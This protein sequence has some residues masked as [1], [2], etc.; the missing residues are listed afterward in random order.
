[1]KNRKNTNRRMVTDGI[2]GLLEVGFLIAAWVWVFL[3]PDDIF[4]RGNADLAT[5]IV[6][7]TLW[8]MTLT[9]KIRQLR[10]NNEE[11]KEIC[12]RIQSSLLAENTE[13]RK[14]HLADQQQILML[15][16]ERKSLYLRNCQLENDWRQLENLVKQ[17]EQSA[18]VYEAE[19]ELPK[20]MI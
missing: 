10:N 11:L 9:S 6:L 7:I 5:L 13:L 20:T 14:Q 17:H 8:G 4:I 2:I 3:N 15:D 18:S 1:M 16:T 12:Q 19:T